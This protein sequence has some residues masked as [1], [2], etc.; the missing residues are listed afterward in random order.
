M[1]LKNASCTNC[2]EEDLEGGPGAEHLVRPAVFDYQNERL[3]IDAL[4]DQAG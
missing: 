4:R 2:L 3:C 1:T